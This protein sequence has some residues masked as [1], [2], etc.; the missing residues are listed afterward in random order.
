VNFVC[1]I[2]NARFPVGQIF[3]FQHNNSPINVNVDRLGGENFRNR[4]YAPS[5][6]GSWVERQPKSNLVHLRMWESLSFTSFTAQG[7]DLVLILIVA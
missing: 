6:A 1:D 3:T 5:P 7:D 4:M 2:N